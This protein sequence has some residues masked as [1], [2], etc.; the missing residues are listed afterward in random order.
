MMYI[1]SDGLTNSILIIGR[2]WNH[3][4]GYCVDHTHFPSNVAHM[5]TSI[6]NLHLFSSKEHVVHS[7]ASWLATDRA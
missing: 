7:A 4:F 1:L 5:I 3:D 2:Q 6:S